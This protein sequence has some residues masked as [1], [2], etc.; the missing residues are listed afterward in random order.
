MTMQTYRLRMTGGLDTSSAPMSVPEGCVVGSKNY[1]ERVVDGG[2][3]TPGGYERYDGRPRPSDA[4]IVAI[5]ADGTWSAAAV[6][7]STAAGGIS[8]ATGTICYYSDTLIALTEVVGTFVNGEVLQVGAASIGIADTSSP[9]VSPLVLNDML[10]GAAEIYR[11]EIEAPPG[12]GP[13]LGACVIDNVVY[14]FRNNE[15]G[16]QQDVWKAT[17]SGWVAVDYPSPWKVY[18][19]AGSGVGSDAGSFFMTQGGATATIHRIMRDEGAWSGGDAAG[20]LA[21]RGPATG[22]TLTTG[23]ATIT[24]FGTVNLTSVAAAAPLAPNG[25]W[26]FVAYQF[27]EQFFSMPPGALPVYGVDRVER[28]GLA[29]GGGNCIE[30]DG[31]MAT[32]LNVNGIVGPWR[33]A[34]HKQHLFVVERHTTLVHSGIENPYAFNA[35]EGG[36]DIKIGGKV[37]ALEPVQGSQDDG[38]MA[39]LSENRTDILYGNDE[40]DWNLVGLSSSVG[41]KVYS[42]Q[43][44]DSLIGMDKEGVRDF[45]PTQNFGN[46]TY[47]T[48]TNHVRRNVVGRTPVGSVVDRA[49]GR[50]RMFFADGS[51]LCGTPR[52]GRW[53]WMPGEYPVALHWVQDWELD[54]EPVMLA[55]GEDGMLYMLDKGRSFDGEPIEAWLKMSYAH[56][57]DPMARKAFRGVSVEIRGES[58]GELQMM[59]DYSYG[60]TAISQNAP[61]AATNNPIPPPGTPWDLG[62]WDT[63]TWDSQYATTLDIGSEGVGDNVSVIFYSRTAK[64]LPHHITTLQHHYLPRRKRRGR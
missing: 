9:S 64:Q 61:S 63:G 40:S 56:C 38:A 35:L 60:D 36:G 7:G 16:T 47:N 27:N 22:G 37:T 43:T 17:S 55:G 50:Y 48:L 59:C 15:A 31:F 5:E 30:F 2:Y 18:F 10:A 24:G 13:L 20:M 11:A 53:S 6:V 26:S 42:T 3:E 28:E 21:L 23:A 54:G 44:I 41:A 62:T 45:R 8:G 29:D 34:C 57:G 39:I 32:P 46:F 1:I 19:D 12:S 25:R 33:I 4:E 49:G 58:A 52:K 14:A 51:W